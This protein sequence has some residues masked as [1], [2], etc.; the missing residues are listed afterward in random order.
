[1]LVTD[2][3]NVLRESCS[4]VCAGGLHPHH[5]CSTQIATTVISLLE[6]LRAAC[7]ASK[8]TRKLFEKH[9]IAVGTSYAS[10]MLKY[11]QDDNNKDYVMLVEDLHRVTNLSSSL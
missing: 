10:Y 4:L 11:W 7:T 6:L 1:M 9:L 2:A 8:A 5:T 3:K